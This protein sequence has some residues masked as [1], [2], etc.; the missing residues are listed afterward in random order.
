MRILILLRGAPG[1]GKST[2]INNYRLNNYTLSTDAL[3]LIMC[4]PEYDVDGNIGIGQSNNKKMFEMMNNILEQRMIR[5]DLTIID[6][7]N[8]TRKEILKY[9]NMCAVYHYRLRIIDFTSVPIERCIRRNE[10]REALRIVPEFVIH[11]F[12]ERF[13]T[14][15][16][17]SGILTINY[18]DED[19]LR[20]IFDMTARSFDLTG[21]YNKLSFIG[22]IH[23]CFSSLQQYTKDCLQ[24][25]TFYV[26]IG[27]YIDR[28]IENDKV[29]KFLLKIADKE[30]VCLLEGNHEKYLTD[31]A[32]KKDVIAEEFVTR[33]I[34]QFENAGIEQKEL[35][36]LCSKFRLC[37]NIKFGDKLFFASHGGVPNLQEGNP[38]FISAKHLIHGVGKYSDAKT[39]ADAWDKNTEENY[40]QVFG[41][42]NVEKGPIKFSKRCFNLQGDVE[43]Q[44]EDGR[45]RVVEYNI[46]NDSFSELEFNN[47]KYASEFE[48]EK[49]P[50]IAMLVSSFRK[51]NYVSEK[52]LFNNVSS[53]N[54]S[55][56][57][58]YDQIWNKITCKTRGL[59]IDTIKNKIVARS[60]DKFFNINEREETQ[61]D[62]LKQSLCYPVVS[63][64]KENGF[65]GIISYVDD[66]LRCFSKSCD[67]DNSEYALLFENIFL[68]DLNINKKFISEY[69]KNT[70]SSMIV[71]VEDPINDPHI[72]KYGKVRLVLLDIVKNENKF[73]KINYE[74]LIELSK[75]FNIDVKQ[76][77]LSINNN[78]ELEKH[79]NDILLSNFEGVVLIDNC[80]F[81]VKVKS[82]FYRTWKV[83]R[84]LSYDYLLND[85][86]F[87]IDK[88]RMSEDNFKI[89]N[90]FKS[91]L[92][93]NIL[94]SKNEK[95]LYDFPIDIISLREKFELRNEST[96]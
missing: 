84:T 65:L 69:L 68:N 9:K 49:N 73:E 42:R 91:F 30:N 11:K 4:N 6:A 23:G 17:P 18:D 7:T 26:F 22:D 31:Y 35:R 55:T 76:K 52:K 27:D 88:D 25:D 79:I 29:I 85:K 78:E 15:T 74:Q 71:E 34:P 61:L 8:S 58:F 87:K 12:Y 51:S 39:V 80:G 14:E 36:K 40:Y 82:D 1:C 64:K 66:K 46:N 60:Y 10:N 94:K 86:N 83:C 41:H 54:F 5:G 92:R 2:F 38:I 72:I 16:I 81:M 70:D 96:K 53:F 21:K 33:T 89:V 48:N 56:N 95:G 47:P 90:D 20:G 67:A 62:Y 75:K 43:E 37:A 59:F 77:L 19:A 57:V 32:Y 13:K 28:G 50:L 24:D 44:T 45:L 63:Y 93:N 3:R